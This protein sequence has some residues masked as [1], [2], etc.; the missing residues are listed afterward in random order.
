MMLAV[1]GGGV[2]LECRCVV[3][4]EQGVLRGWAAARVWAG[5]LEVSGPLYLH[6]RVA[7]SKFSSV[8]SWNVQH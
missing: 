7:N 4:V 1:G 5:Q 3:V 6:S 8:D 2:P